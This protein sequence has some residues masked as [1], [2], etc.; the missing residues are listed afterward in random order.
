MG[1]KALERLVEFSGT[2]IGPMAV[3]SRQV[4]AAG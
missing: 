2:N 3:G 4:L 1:R